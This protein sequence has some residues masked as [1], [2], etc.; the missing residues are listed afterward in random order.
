MVPTIYKL[1]K[2]QKKGLNVSG[3]IPMARKMVRTN[4]APS[5]GSCNSHVTNAGIFPHL[6]PYWN[7]VAEFAEHL[8]VHKFPGKTKVS[9]F[10]HALLAP[11]CWTCWICC[12]IHDIQLFN[13]WV[14][15]KMGYTPK[16]IAI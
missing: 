12:V 4:V 13:I 11:T 5:V 7:G 8:K 15:L 2:A 9:E 16:K 14:C 6:S 10:Q 1:Y 3:N